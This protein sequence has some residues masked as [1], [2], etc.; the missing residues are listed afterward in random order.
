[1]A[2]SIPSIRIFAPFSELAK[3]FPRRDHLEKL[4]SAHARNALRPRHEILRLELALPV[5]D[6]LRGIGDIGSEA[7]EADEL[8]LML[9][10]HPLYER[11]EHAGG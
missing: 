4:L 11:K 6:E 5:V 10:P 2:S 8:P 9:F 1:M 7:G 3:D